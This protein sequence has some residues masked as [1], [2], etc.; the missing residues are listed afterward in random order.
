[1]CLKDFE[2]RR[3]AFHIV[4]GLLIVFLLAVEVFNAWTLLW[5][6]LVGI[7]IS[8]ISM[9]K[10]IPGISWL[11]SIFERESELKRFPGKGTITF[12][13]GALLSV[14]LFQ[15]DIALASIT[16]L[17]LGD[18]FSHLIG[19]YYGRIKHPLNNVKLLEGTIAGIFF[20]AIGAVFFV[21]FYEAVA[22]SA[23]AIFSEAVEIK[24]RKT[25]VD[26]NLTIPLIAGLVI[27]I[28]RHIFV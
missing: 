26:D 24:I 20:A 7:A 3:Q 10:D 5:I 19:K 23:V 2:F 21:T 25:K 1:M 6:L 28:M 18:S 17:T 8:L 4:M 11:L 13:I 27:V 15:K 22:A 9:K 14:L 12:F 16:I